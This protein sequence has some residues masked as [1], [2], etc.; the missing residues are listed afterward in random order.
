MAN[1]EKNGL[2]HKMDHFEIDH[3]ENRSLQSD[4]LRIDLYME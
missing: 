1:Y 4:Q 3:F 2:L